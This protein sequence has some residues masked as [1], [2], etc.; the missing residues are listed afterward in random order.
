MPFISKL[1]GPLSLACA[2]VVGCA[3][4]LA[5][6]PLAAHEAYVWQHQWGPAMRAAVQQKSSQINVLHVLALTTLAKD[7]TLAP[8]AVDVAALAGQ[9]PVIAVVRIEGTAQLAR[10]SQVTLQ[11]LLDVAQA[12]Q[13]QGVDVVGLEVDHDC[14]TSQLPTYAT[15]LTEQKKL[16][17]P[18]SLAIT[19][20]PTW[21]SSPAVRDVAAAVDRVTVQLHAISAPT[22]FDPVVARTYCVDWATATGRPFWVALPTYAVTL[23]AGPRIA[24]D[25]EVVRIFVEGLR[26]DPL[27]G[28]L[29]VVWFRLAYLGDGD[30]WSAE[31]LHAVASG[32]ALRGS[33]AVG[34]RAVEPNLWDIVATN[35]GNVTGSPP[36]VFK[37]SG[38][39]TRLEGVRGC[40]STGVRMSCPRALQV[41]PGQA[42]TLGYV[43]GREVQVVN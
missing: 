6:V 25:P 10:L 23:K 27:P 37:F 35:T 14:A 9:G 11:P 26:A 43:R 32:H 12:W 16:V 8:A 5:R 39:V 30:A 21:A 19:A 1:C 13:R 33:V 41:A 3:K 4:P 15:W 29:G 22:L 28:V 31:T 24:A 2:L 7:G 36:E 40:S 18:R 17:A 42:V 20:L 34:L 38:E